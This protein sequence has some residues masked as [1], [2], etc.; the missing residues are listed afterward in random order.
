L[1]SQEVKDKS[2]ATSIKKYGTIHPNKNKNI[3]KKIS[4]SL[5]N[6]SAEEKEIIK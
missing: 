5:K 4:D 3:S 1:Q 6:K 2:I